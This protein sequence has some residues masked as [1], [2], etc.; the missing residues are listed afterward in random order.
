MPL[1]DQSYRA[2]GDPGSAEADVSI[3]E[4]KGPAAHHSARNRAPNPPSQ[5]ALVCLRQRRQ[6]FKLG[7]GVSCRRIYECHPRRHFQGLLMSSHVTPVRA[8]NADTDLASTATLATAVPNGRRTGRASGGQGLRPYD[9]E[10]ASAGRGSAPG[11][12]DS[13]MPGLASRPVAH[14]R[15]PDRARL[16]QVVQRAFHLDQPDAAERSLRDGMPAQAGACGA[17]MSVRLRR[18]RVFVGQPADDRAPP[19][20]ASGQVGD[21]P[22]WLGWPLAQRAMRPMCVVVAV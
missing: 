21:V 1:Q 22:T 3:A 8:D 18:P 5:P 20:F 9:P 10:S 14:R 19:D 17:R 11:A 7:S 6:T 12:G 15:Q 2:S 4:P 13:G 16:V